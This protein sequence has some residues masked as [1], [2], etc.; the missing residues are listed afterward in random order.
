MPFTVPVKYQWFCSLGRNQ[1]R[2]AERK[3]SKE[4][5]QEISYLNLSAFSS[6][7]ISAGARALPVFRSSLVGSWTHHFF[8]P[9]SLYA[10]PEHTYFLSIFLTTRNPPV[11]GDND[12]NRQGSNS[13]SFTFNCCV[14]IFLRNPASAWG[15]HRNQ[16][17][18]V[19]VKRNLNLWTGGW[20]PWTPCLAGMPML[21]LG[22]VV[23][24]LNTPFFIS[25]NNITIDGTVQPISRD[26]W[27]V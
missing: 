13:V 24:A 14:D 11:Y 19:L 9:R 20:F 12:P 8:E 18:A 15:F 6:A 22:E 26:E 17:N 4:V 23:T 21:F 10:C 16:F 1:R 2:K 7:L 5:F 25:W 27:V 3:L